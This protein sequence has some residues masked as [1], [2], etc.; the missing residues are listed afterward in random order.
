MTLGLRSATTD[1]VWAVDFEFTAPPGG[2]PVPICLVCELRSATSVGCRRLAPP[3]GTGPDTQ[4]GQKGQVRSL[5]LDA[6]PYGT[7]PDTLLIAY[8]SS[9]EWGCHLA[10]DWPLPVRILD[11]FAEFR[12]LTKGCPCR[13]AMACS[14]P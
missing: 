3:Y 2:R 4:Q 14:V 8:F 10:L 12:C 9:A 11:L 13:A 6:P 5:R 1:D 7:G